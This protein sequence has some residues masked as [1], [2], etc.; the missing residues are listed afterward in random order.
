MDGLNCYAEAGESDVRAANGFARARA[1]PDDAGDPGE[2]EVILF[3]LGGGGGG[4]SE[5]DEVA[6][7]VSTIK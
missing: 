6:E 5:E 7:S 2:G 1:E 4:E 3:G